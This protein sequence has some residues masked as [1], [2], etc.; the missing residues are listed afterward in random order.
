VTTPTFPQ[1]YPCPGCKADVP[2]RATHC[3]AC[4]M[5]L[6]DD[7]EFASPAERMQAACELNA[8]GIEHYRQRMIRENPQAEPDE[9]DAMVRTWQMRE[10][11]ELP[12]G[13][14]R[15]KADCCQNCE[16]LII[17]LAGEWVHRDG[18]VVH[19]AG[20]STVAEPIEDHEIAEAGR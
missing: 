11:E 16:R 6:R 7:R 9:I 1:T 4:G 10:D 3:P 13:F 2:S 20:R 19:C 18:K 12:K 5:Q 15:Y 14:T 8:A 17:L